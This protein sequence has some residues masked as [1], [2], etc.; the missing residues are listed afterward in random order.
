MQTR[1][2]RL[3]L[4]ENDDDIGFNALSPIFDMMNHSGDAPSRFELLQKTSLNTFVPGSEKKYHGVDELYLGVKYLTNRIVAGEEIY[5]NYDRLKEAHEFLLSYGFVPQR[6]LSANVYEDF[7]SL[8][9][10]KK[11]TVGIYLENLD[12]NIVN[13]NNSNFATTVQVAS[14]PMG[15]LAL[16]HRMGIYMGDSFSVFRDG[17]STNLLTTLGIIVA[18]NIDIQLINSKLSETLYKYQTGAVTTSS[19]AAEVNDLSRDIIY[20][21]VL[22]INKKNEKRAFDLLVNILRSM[23]AEYEKAF[24]ISSFLTNV[25]RKT[26][27]QELLDFNRNILLQ[28][29]DWAQTY[30]NSLPGPEELK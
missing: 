14:K 2:N 21:C 13:S 23:I 5:L 4:A 15:K 8:T 10:P 30:R 20:N 6:R 16:L 17:I 19:G 27:I 9:L 26:I 12:S 1:N 3:N 29:V 11:F 25:R 18:E 7:V 28:A 22:E 24:E